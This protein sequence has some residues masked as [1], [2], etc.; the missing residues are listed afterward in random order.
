MIS[1]LSMAG[2]IVFG[3]LEFPQEQKK[4]IMEKRKNNIRMKNK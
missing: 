2:A 4:I 1:V 3:G